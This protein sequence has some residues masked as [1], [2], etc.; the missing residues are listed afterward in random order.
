MLGIIIGI[1]SV[2]I[3][4]AAG[5]GVKQQISGFVD[6]LGPNTIIVLPIPMLNDGG[7][8]QTFTQSASFL[9]TIDNDDVDAIKKINHIAKVDAIVLPSGI[10]AYEDK[11]LIPFLIGGTSQVVETFKLEL[12]KGR[13]IIEKDQEDNKKIV[14]IGA[15]S[16][17]K[18]GLK[19]EDIGKKIKIGKEELEI[20]GF[21][22]E[23][24]RQIFGFDTNNIVM[25]P[26]TT[27][28]DLNKRKTLDR[29]FVKI[30]L[31]EN[32]SSTCDEIKKTLKDRHGEEDFSV[33]EQK[34]AL[35]L[36]DQ[37]LDVLTALLSAIASISLL[38]GGIGIMNIMLVSVTERTKEIGIRK[39][40]G[41][42][43]GIILIQFLIEAVILTVLGTMLAI[44][45]AFT[46]A[47]LVNYKF[48]DQFPI[49][50]VIE[51]QSV[52]LAVSI[53][54]AIGIIFG[55]FPAII[56]ARK[57]PIEALRYE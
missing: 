32:I 27:A 4:T 23:S 51:A 10:L 13:L 19:D 31:K 9:S 18:L 36:W 3:L 22:K 49:T 11:K 5:A 21:F 17:E 34:D 1:Y 26:Y 24:D 54:I 7:N 38:V 14:V 57:N 44:G 47:Y 20:I 43:N 25:M 41:A 33:L 48:A 12:N 15:T 53:S 8:S 55:L 6:T 16:K 37:I 45:M 56:A 50:L 35:D 28:Q 30:D 40:I 52:I 29:V 2:I 46:T 42:S 39:A